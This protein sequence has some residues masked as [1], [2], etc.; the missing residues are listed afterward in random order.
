MTKLFSKKKTCG[1]NG[2]IGRTSLSLDCCT[3]C[4]LNIKGV[5]A[6]QLCQFNLIVLVKKKWGLEENPGY[7]DFKSRYWKKIL[8]TRISNPSTENR[9]ESHYNRENFPGASRPSKTLTGVLI[10]T[11]NWLSLGGGEFAVIIAEPWFFFCKVARN[12][13][14]FLTVIFFVRSLSVYLFL[15]FFASRGSKKGQ[16]T[17]PGRLRYEAV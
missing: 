12:L 16:K 15:P 14:F 2:S 6:V 9:I 13:K 8:G 10:S 4:Y 5:H 17:P 7:R 1:T 3:Y 11:H